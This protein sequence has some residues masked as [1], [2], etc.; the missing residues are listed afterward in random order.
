MTRSLKYIIHLQYTKLTTRTAECCSAAQI[1]SSITRRGGSPSP[2]VVHV[3]VVGHR[4]ARE[5]IVKTNELRRNLSIQEQDGRW[6]LFY[7]FI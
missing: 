2:S 6:S 3:L 1:V 7:K 5:E 4:R